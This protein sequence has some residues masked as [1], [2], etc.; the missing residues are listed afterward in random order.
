MSK[1]LKNCKFA[2]KHLA[3]LD[4]VSK[5]M[6]GD[7]FH[8]YSK[9]IAPRECFPDSSEGALSEGVS[10]LVLGMKTIAGFLNT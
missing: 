6:F 2:F 7:N 5:A 10:K 9:T 4:V 8:R 1:V 3:R